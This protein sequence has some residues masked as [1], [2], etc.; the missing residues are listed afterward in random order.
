[1]GDFSSFCYF[2]FLFSQV[3]VIVFLYRNVP[4]E[5]M[6]CRIHGGSLDQTL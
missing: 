1:M 3:H 2:C 6:L 5:V 4:F